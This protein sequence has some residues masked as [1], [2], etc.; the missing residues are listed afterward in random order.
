MPNKKFNTIKFV[1]YL[2]VG[3]ILF[4]GWAGVNYYNYTHVEYQK[5][6]EIQETTQII[7]EEVNEIEMIQEELRMEQRI[8][9]LPP[10]A[11][12]EVMI[13]P[14]A[15]ME[16]LPEMAP[17]TSVGGLETHVE[18]PT[19]S[20]APPEEP[21]MEA[22]PEEYI[23]EEAYAMDTYYLELEARILELEV[24]KLRLEKEEKELVEDIKGLF[25]IFTPNIQNPLL[26]IVIL[27]ILAY[28]F[29]K[30]LDFIFRRLEERYAAQ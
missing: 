25:D 30:M 20:V 6:T 27:P 23:E 8:V 22:L 2:T 16:A 18:E 24:E 14:H 17:E 29:K 5:S 28:L 13:E 11:A 9:S 26:N 7:Q 12:G 4:F 1:T 10:T 3:L 21:V 19:A 15:A